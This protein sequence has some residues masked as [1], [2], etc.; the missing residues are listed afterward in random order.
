M[1]SVDSLPAHPGHPEAWLFLQGRD[2][3]NVFFRLLQGL[4]F[5]PSCLYSERSIPFMQKIFDLPGARIFFDT[6]RIMVLQEFADLLNQI[7][8]GWFHHVF[9]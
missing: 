2:R 5:A 8:F 9:Q 6:E 4:F 3:I 1:G 7:C